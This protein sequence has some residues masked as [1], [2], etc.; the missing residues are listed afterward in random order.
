MDSKMEEEVEQPVLP[1]SVKMDILLV[2]A[3]MQHQNGLRVNDYRRYAH[4][5]KKKINK[6][7]KIFKLTQGK[8][9]FQKVPITSDKLKDNKILL[10]SILECERNWAYG[11][12]HKQELTAIG[13]DIKRLRHQITRKFQRA[14]TNAK[15]IFEMCQKVGDTQTQLEA[16]AYYAFIFSNFL[17]FKRN[18]SEALNLL[19]KASNIYERI[20]QLKDSIESL[21]YKDKINN[22]KTSMRLCLDN[23]SNSKDKIDDEEEFEK[24]VNVEDI[25]LSEK[26]EEIKKKN[27]E[28]NAKNPD[29]Y[30]IKYHGMN[31]PI[32]N[33][34]L[35]N[36]FIKLEE[37][38]TKIE[39]EEN[40]TK[41]IALFQDYYNKI[42]EMIKIVKKEKTEENSQQAENF[43][44][45]YSK[46]LNYIENL[47]LKKYIEKNL[48]FIKDYS[49]DFENVET[50]T[51][52]F[53]KDNLKLRVKPQEI[54]K[55]YDNLLEYQ[56]Q[57]INLEKENPDQSYLI[58]LNYKD[59]IYSLFKVFFAGLFYILNKKFMDAY[60]I[61]HYFQ[62]KVKE[63]N[64]FF[65]LH[66]LTNVTSLKLLKESTGVYEHLCVF[67]INSAF[68]KMSKENE[69]NNRMQIDDKKKETKKI[70]YN[71]YLYNVMQEDGKN[72]LTKDNFDM[73]G[74]NIK[75]SYQDYIEATSKNNFN[76]Y[77]QI[78]QL[79]PNTKLIPPKPIVF[80][81]TYEQFSY[82]NLEEKTKKQQKGFLGRTF[83]YW[84]GS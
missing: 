30:E 32:K 49:K 3:S 10:I 55:L 5:C 1:G 84:F 43:S 15:T 27:I 66:N 68:V 76:N 52:L 65:E 60:T 58:D 44:K 22:I 4:F 29:Q 6:L 20:S 34:K 69:K 18:F 74:D 7:R 82:P 23:L 56:G 17:I 11:M 19:K 67:I 62:E 12:F 9:K 79:P 59:K 35:K 40:L 51:L 8:K 47:R 73:M 53:E 33:E 64:E 28:S 41:K 25:E 80:D 26:I 63:A 36:L 81:L 13:E 21:E 2:T 78:M 42:D 45:I 16:E 83:G 48:S 71:P 57:L 61:M 75:I 70:K 77:T 14:S 39:K 50:I 38:S 54:I 46:I 37:L 31:L 24:N 72:E